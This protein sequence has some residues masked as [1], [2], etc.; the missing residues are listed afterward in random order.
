MGYK[1]KIK[2]LFNQMYKH[3]LENDLTHKDYARPVKLPRMMQ[4][5]QKDHLL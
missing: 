5:V 1:E 3:A 4:R 2:V